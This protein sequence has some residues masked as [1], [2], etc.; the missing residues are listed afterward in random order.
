MLYVKH[1]E[2][3]RTVLRMSGKSYRDLELLTGVDDSTISLLAGGQRRRLGTDKAERLC[4]ELGVSVDLLFTADPA[5]VI[6]LPHPHRKGPR[7]AVEQWRP[8]PGS[9]RYE[10][11]TRGR[12][13]SSARSTPRM[14]KP[15]VSQGGYEFVT[16]D[17]RRRGIHQLVLE[18]FVGPAPI[19]QV[20]RHLDGDPSNNH[21]PNLAW[22]TRSR[23][24]LDREEHNSARLS[25]AGGALTSQLENGLGREAS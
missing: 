1:P 14:L 3:L 23:N 22:G 16:V 17:G 21:L 20:V 6:T 7:A 2:A 10:V 15:H 19:G 12:V 4:Q 9:P 18:T 11:S 24:A 5:A 25:Q 13:R 8:I